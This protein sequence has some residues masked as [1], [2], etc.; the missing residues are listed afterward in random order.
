MNDADAVRLRDAIE[1]ERRRVNDQ[2]ANLQQSFRRC[3]ASTSHAQEVRTFGAGRM[4]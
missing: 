1:I 3:G 4:R 2:I